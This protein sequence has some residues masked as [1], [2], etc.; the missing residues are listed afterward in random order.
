MHDFDEDLDERLNIRMDK[1][2][3]RR[4]SADGAG[5]SQVKTRVF[6]TL[7]MDREHV[8][9]DDYMTGKLDR[10]AYENSR[11]D[12]PAVIRFN[13]EET[14]CVEWFATLREKVE[15]YKGKIMSKPLRSFVVDLAKHTCSCNFWDLVG[16][17]CRHGVTAIHRKVDDP[18]KPKGKSK[19]GGP[20]KKT[21]TRAHAQHDKPDMTPA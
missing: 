10:G 20:S 11:D 8:M 2:E 15:N 13:K 12:R 21:K 5:T 18:I 9:E 16:I 3:P 17:P 14:Q 4:E 6:T 19:K 7:E 1:G